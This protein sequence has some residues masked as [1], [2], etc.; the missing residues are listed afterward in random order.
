MSIE[1]DDQSMK[2]NDHI[3]TYVY[4]LIFVIF[5]G[6]VGKVSRMGLCN[7]LLIKYRAAVC[8]LTTA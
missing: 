4:L 1:F 7:S 8:M 3:E 6:H 2:Y 5:A